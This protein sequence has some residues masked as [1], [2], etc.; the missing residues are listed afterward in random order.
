MDMKLAISNIA[1]AAERDI[2][3]YGWMKQYGYSGLEI[4]PTRIFPK[5][6]YENLG[7][8]VKWSQALQ[9]NYSLV[10]PSIQSIWFG[11]AENLFGSSIERRILMEYTKKAIDFASAIRCRNLVFG[12]PR[13]R[14]VS[15]ESDVMIGIEFFRELGEY[16][17]SRN[18]VIGMEANPP[19]Y[20]TNYI[21]DTNAALQLVRAVDSKGFLLNL[22]VGTM[23]LNEESVSE[24]KKQVKYINHVHISEPALAIIQKRKMHKELSE[25]LMG[26]GYQ[27]FVSIE[28]GRMDS[29]EG[30]EGVLE[31]VRTVFSEGE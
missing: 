8:A 25:I 30:I 9:D 16:A 31:Y 5:N 19:V 27:G 21:N 7:L 11:R 29:I 13:N 18:A 4:A 12:C 14:N 15:K 17:V 1:W 24:L 23:I 6:P 22:D 2:T 28:M 3:V 20:H 26:E 10:V